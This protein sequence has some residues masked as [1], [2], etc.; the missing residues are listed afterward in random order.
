MRWQ[1]RQGSKNIEDRRGNKSNMKRVGG[2]IGIGTILLIIA[3]LIFGGD[4]SEVLRG[5][6]QQSQTMPE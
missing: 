1:G 6:Q 3:T 4:I 2:G 5:V